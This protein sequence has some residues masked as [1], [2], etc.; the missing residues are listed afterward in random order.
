MGST[1]SEG[2]THWCGASRV[3]RTSRLVSAAWVLSALALLQVSMH[4]MRKGRNMKKSRFSSQ[5]RSIALTADTPPPPLSLPISSSFTSLRFPVFLTQSLLRFLSSVDSEVW[6]T[7]TTP[8]DMWECRTSCDNESGGVFYATLE[9]L[10]FW[11]AL[12]RVMLHK[13][14]SILWGDPERLERCSFL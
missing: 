7:S 1:K 14:N 4:S 11:L 9:Q 5:L 8:A 12:E 3:Q 6:L 13:I 10:C 2:S